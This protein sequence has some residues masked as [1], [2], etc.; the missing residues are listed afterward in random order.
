MDLNAMSLGGPG[1]VD[2]VTRLLVLWVPRVFSALLILLVAHFVATGIKWALASTLNHMPLA[3]TANAG[4][5]KKEE[6]LGARLGEIGYW[7]VYLIGLIAALNTLGLNQ[8]VAPL[9]RLVAGFFEFLP[10]LVGAGI[11]FFIGWVVAMVTRRVVA[12]TIA[13]FDIGTIAQK[14]GLKDVSSVSLAKAVGQIVFVIIIIPVAIAGLQALKI[15]AISDPAV[16]VLGQILDTLPKLIGA[17]IIL[18]ISF[19]IARWVAGLIEQTLPAIGFENIAK[20]IGLFASTPVEEAPASKVVSLIATIAIM[21]FASIEAAKMLEFQVAAVIITQILTLGGKILFGG[22]I[23]A[24]GIALANLISSAIDKSSGSEIAS[25]ISRWATIA[26]SVAMGLRFMGIAD[27][28][29]NMAFGLILGA[30]A[31]AAAIAFGWGGRDAAAKLLDK[32]VNK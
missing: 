22:V 9:N 6:T 24:A 1:S 3:K 32:W 15:S 29:I 5:S 31:V 13:A 2:A 12:S 10:N 8:V 25:N 7:L 21:M 11:I 17:I 19:A 18:G 23:I 20:Q 30:A 4:A 14:I 26:L 27:D 28:I 16:A